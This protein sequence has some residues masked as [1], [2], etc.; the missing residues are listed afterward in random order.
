AFDR[1]V[2][3]LGPG[4]LTS[5]R[6]PEAGWRVLGHGLEPRHAIVSQETGWGG[7]ALIERGSPGALILIN[8]AEI[9]DG[10]ATLEFDDVVRLGTAEVTYRPTGLK[11]VKAGPFLRD[12]K[13]GP[14]YLLTRRFTIG[15]D[16]NS[17][18]VL[19]GVDISRTHAEIAKDGDGYVVRPHGAS[20]VSVNGVRV[21][22]QANLREG[23]DISIGDSVFRFTT[24]AGS[25]SAV[26][27][28]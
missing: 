19:N 10:R 8:G 18:I 23:D 27:V 9:T 17:S 12:R 20:V 24:D 25:S 13:R 7:R 16:S 6:A 4:V 14:P 2:R 28:E 11:T 15:R 1:T 3:Q 26:S 5:G 22:R 21:S